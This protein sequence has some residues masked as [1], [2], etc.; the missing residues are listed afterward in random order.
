VTMMTNA[1]KIAS[2]NTIATAIYQ[3]VY[4][5]DIYEDFRKPITN[6]IAR[7]AIT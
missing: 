2:W 1:T 4:K 7:M 3:T 5:L 6:R